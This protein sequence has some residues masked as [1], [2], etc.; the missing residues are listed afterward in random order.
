MNAPSSAS[1]TSSNFNIERMQWHGPISAIVKR[2]VDQP[3]WWM[4][5][6]RR[7]WPIARVPFTRWAIVTRFED[8]QEVLATEQ[9]FRVPFGPRMM[10]LMPG[11]KFVLAM[12]DSDE[13]RRQRRQIMEVFRLEDIAEIVAPGPPRSPRRFSRDAEAG[14][15]RSRAC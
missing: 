10:Q 11:P 8:V 9:V 12:D 7:F 2:L 14:S 13:Y 3:Q 5:L 1:L 4:G 6:L 15:M